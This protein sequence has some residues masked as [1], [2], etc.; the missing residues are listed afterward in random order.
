MVR[1]LYKVACKNSPM[2][3]NELYYFI[4]GVVIV[5]IPLVYILKI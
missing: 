5:A 3:W 2:T 1:E 4:I